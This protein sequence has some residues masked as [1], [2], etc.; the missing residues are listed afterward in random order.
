[1]ES[2]RNYKEGRKD[3]LWES[4]IK[5][6]RQLRFSRNFKDGKR[7]GLWEWYSDDG[8]L[9]SRQNWKDGKQI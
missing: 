8:Q 5:K 6:G 9:E 2:K 3:G 1:L 7:D 4:F